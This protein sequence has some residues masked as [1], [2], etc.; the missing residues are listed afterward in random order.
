MNDAAR[1]WTKRWQVERL[2][3]FSGTEFFRVGG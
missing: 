2:G 1:A 3:K